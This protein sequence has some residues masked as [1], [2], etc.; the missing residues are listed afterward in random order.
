M[1]MIAASELTKHFGTQTCFEQG[2]FQLS[3]GNRVGLIGANGTGKTTL[4]RIIQGQTEYEGNLL[5]RKNLR[6]A[7]LDQNP[8]LPAGSTV[9]EAVLQ[10]DPEL[11][12]LHHEIDQIHHDLE[13]PNLSPK[14]TDRLLTRLTPLETQ[15]ETRGGYTIEHR[16]EQILEGLGFAEAARGAKVETLSGGEKTRVAL[17]QLLLLEPDLWL[18]DEP[19]NHLDIDGIL[20][21]E[22]FL[23]NSSAAAII[24]SHDRRFLDQ[25]TQATWEIEGGRIWTYPAPYSRARELREERLKSAWKQFE[26]QKDHIDQQESFIR[27]YGAGQRARQAQGR[28]KRL[29]RL[30]RLDRP[31]DQIRAMSL[32]FPLAE[33]SGLKTLTVRDISRGFEGRN[34]FQNLSFEVDRGET[35]GIV[36]PNGSGKTTLLRTLTGEGTSET[37]EVFWGSRVHRGLLNQQDDFPADERTV[38]QYMREFERKRNDQELRNLLGAMLFTGET[39]EKSLS[40][41]SGGERKRLRFTELLLEGKNVLL[42]DEPTNHLDIPSREVLE[43]ALSVWEGTMMIVSHDR[44][45]LDLMA[46]RIIWI[47]D[48]EVHLTDGGYEEAARAR[49]QRQQ[50][51]A[52]QARA[53]K[54][55]E[56]KQVEKP[57][58]KKKPASPLSKIK[59]PDLEKRIIQYES[60]LKKMEEQFSLPE[61]FRD[62]Y[63]VQEIKKEISRVRKELF[64]LENEYLGRNS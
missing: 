20:Y 61:V 2:E 53:I 37:G 13:K 1:A 64:E 55:R 50:K 41:L 48:G 6:I 34:L 31:Q 24:T 29:E 19:T 17:S 57:A 14:E 10:S 35:I 54:N 15:F 42:L 63:K 45:F 60:D 47:E 36:G 59:T 56:E 25:V 58:G 32:K 4:F 28:L 5:K 62:P 23:N 46:D 38:F 7:A 11:S 49:L 18:L 52:M 8:Q 40:F 51:K 33:R 9:L 21:L 44:Y 30:E 16:A 43:L 12:R 22:S 27:R 39:T 3:S 26:K